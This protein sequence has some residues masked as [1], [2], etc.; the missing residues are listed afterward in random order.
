MIKILNGMYAFKRF[1][2][3]GVIKVFIPYFAISSE[4]I[5]DGNSN[6]KGLWIIS[7][8]VGSGKTTLFN[9]LTGTQRVSG[10][11]VISM[12]NADQMK[13]DIINPIP[14]LGFRNIMMCDTE[15]LGGVSNVDNQ[16]GNVK[17]AGAFITS[18][19]LTFQRMIKGCSG[20]IFCIEIEQRLTDK[21]ILYFQSLVKEVGN[22][23]V[24]I[25]VTKYDKMKGRSSEIKAINAD[26][27]IELNHSTISKQL[28]LEKSQVSFVKISID[29]DEPDNSD[30]KELMRV[31][32][33]HGGIAENP[34]IT[35][36]RRRFQIKASTDK[37]L[38]SEYDRI[39]QAG[40][41]AIQNL[42]LSEWFQISLQLSFDLSIK[43][44]QYLLWLL[45]TG[46]A[47]TA[48]A[49]ERVVKATMKFAEELFK[50]DD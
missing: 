32:S 43:V 19:M 4:S 44:V 31:I 47:F 8:S 33:S 6:T 1:S 38:E 46:G 20:V 15:G 42:L 9:H 50:K 26:N 22:I 24:V 29:E 30:V 17:N 40:N 27:W 5:C 10:S 11:S 2:S 23:P 25:C 34:A 36:L 12:T 45:Q 16:V 18:L 41:Q 48:F 14:I 37:M 3:L 35:A 13:Q 49:M 21:Q 28:F 7:G 39:V